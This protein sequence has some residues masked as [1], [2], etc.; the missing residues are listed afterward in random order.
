MN[1]LRILVLSATLS[2]APQAWTAT[3]VNCT[4]SAGGLAFGIYNPLSAVANASTESLK[5]TCNGS[6][7]G[8]ATVTLNVTFGTGL[9]GSYATRRCSPEPMR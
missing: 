9:S 7:T 8:S 1:T 3:T 2:F 4:A 5:V 6:G